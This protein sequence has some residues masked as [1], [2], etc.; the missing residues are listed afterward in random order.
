[1]EN[2]KVL[3]YTGGALLLGAVGYFVWSFFQ[4]VEIPV[5]QTTVVL[6]SEPKDD[7]PKSTPVVSQNT[8][9]RNNPFT[10]MLDTK[11]DPIKTPDIYADIR[12][13][14]LNSTTSNP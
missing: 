9:P 10:A 3:L 13:F 7:K 14:P 12:N 6:G 5:G 8:P 4:K 2:K 11:F 1:M